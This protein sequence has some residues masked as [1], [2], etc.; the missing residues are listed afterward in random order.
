M[1]GNPEAASAQ[2]PAVVRLGSVDSTQAVAFALAESGAADGSAVVADSQRAGRGRR[3]RRWVDEPGQSL[4]TSIILRPRLLPATWPLL[5]LAAAVAVARAVRWLAGVEARLKWPNDVV[6]GGRKLAGILLESRTGEGAVVVVGIG[7]NVGQHRW[8]PDLE[9]RAISVQEAS[10]RAIDREAL[11]VAVIEELALWR[12]RLEGEGVAPV[13]AEWLALSDTIG[14]TVSVDGVRG[15]AVDLDA[16]GAL[17]IE[18]DGVRHLAV[19]G[20][21]SEEGTDAPRH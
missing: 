17:V 16:T 6:V 7:I 13:R 19:T 11:R 15:V 8:P 18:Q 2:A 1:T 12:G 4:L 20:T 5:S 14:R 9:G 10:G 21:A 3:D